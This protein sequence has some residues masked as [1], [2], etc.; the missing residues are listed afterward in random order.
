[1]F[2]LN[3]NRSRSINRDVNATHRKDH[4]PVEPGTIQTPTLR[5]HVTTLFTRYKHSSRGL[6]FDGRVLS[7][8]SLSAHVMLLFNESVTYLARH[9]ASKRIIGLTFY[10]KRYSE[11][12]VN[13]PVRYSKA[14]G[15]RGSR[16]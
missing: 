2:H 3:H 13:V 7:E 1:M 5:V 9:I 11:S 6:D 15:C 10:L 14:F 16:G 4:S 8:V 12:S